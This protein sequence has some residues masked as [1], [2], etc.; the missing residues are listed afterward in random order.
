MKKIL[1]LFMLGITILSAKTIFDNQI[2]SN[3]AFSFMNETLDYSIY[4]TDSFALKS[5]NYKKSIMTFL[6][7]N[8]Q[9]TH[10]AYYQTK[11][12]KL[13]WNLT[14]GIDYWKNENQDYYFWYKGIKLSSNIGKNLFMNGYW[15]A[16]HFKGDEKYYNDSP[17]LT[18]WRKPG[19]ET[20]YLDKLVA[21]I[22]YK[23]KFGDLYLGRGT[24]QISNNI[25]GS[26]ILSD[27]SNDYGYFGFD[28]N[29]DK[30]ELQFLHGSLTPDSLQINNI[31]TN[32]NDKFDDKYLALH[33]IS[34]QY[35]KNIQ[36]YFGESIVYG[37]RGIDINY[38][39]P[40]TFYRV[41]EHNQHDRDNALIF[42]GFNFKYNHNLIYFNSILD[43]LKK[44]E[45]F[46]NWWGNKYGV[47]LG[48]AFQNRRFTSAY[49]CTAIRPWIYTHKYLVNKYSNDGQPLGF[50]NGTN[51]VQFSTQQLYKFT[52]YF[53]TTLEINY[54]I[55]GSE[56]N[57]F[58]INYLEIDDQINDEAF[59]LQ[60]DITREINSKLIFNYDYSYHHRFK[61][62]F[63]IVK[64]IDEE[65]S[66]QTIISYQTRY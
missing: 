21:K 35:N 62:S 16:G 46:G 30:I 32:G 61:L 66:L 25:G 37:S 33:K 42:G 13:A 10:F 50:P 57:N 28:L 14:T 56:A 31:A 49:E 7:K 36:F 15:T 18:G 47:Q 11:N 12:L 29:F 27:V 39:L 60:G 1:V 22:R 20:I 40:H 53:S 3:S 8:H 58:A 41:S 2:T 4:E 24:H 64:P 38:L 51:L 48:Y 34:Y 9:P 17:L 54:L 5:N 65:M 63:D 59:W 26:I 23:T 52:E 55:Q 44:S 43:E 45:I 19:E 6:S